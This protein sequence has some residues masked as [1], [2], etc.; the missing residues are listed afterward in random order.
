MATL[1]GYRW[2]RAP[3]YPLFEILVSWTVGYGWVVTN[4]LAVIA[5]M[6]CAILLCILIKQAG[7]SSRVATVATLAYTFAPVIWI[8]STT[9]MDYIFA[10]VC[11]LGSWYL[12]GKSRVNLSAVVLGLA[13]GFRP[14]TGVFI[15][16]MIVGLALFLRQRQSRFKELVQ[17][18]IIYLVLSA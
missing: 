8:E 5:G 4:S 12:L 13:V 18:G 15:V 7:V 2:T 9:T 17:S 3:G 16:P 11:L 1:G 10:D 6:S 14:S